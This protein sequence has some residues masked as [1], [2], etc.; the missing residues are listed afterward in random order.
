[1]AQ[2][3]VLANVDGH[4]D[5]HAS[6][7]V[8]QRDTPSVAVKP[9]GEASVK[10]ETCVI[11]MSSVRSRMESEGFSKT[12]TNFI[13]SSWRSSTKGAYDVFIRKWELFADK[14]KVD[15][16]S[17]TVKDAVN[18]L[19]QLVEEGFSYSAIATA[20]SA[21]SSFLKLDNTD[22][23]FGQQE[24]VKRFMKGLFEENPTLPRYV[25]TWD[26]NIVLEFLKS[27]SP[28][29]KLTL[30]ELTLKLCMLLALVTG[31]RCQTL[32]LLNTEHMVV[33]NTKCIFY[34]MSLIKHSRRGSHQE[35]I[36]IDAYPKCTE[37]CVVTVLKEYL[38]RTEMFRK[39]AGSQLF[40]T[41]VSPHSPASKDTVSRWIKTTLSL[42]G[43]EL[44]YS[45]HSTRMAATSAADKCGVPIETI[46]KAAGW[47]N[48][49][50]FGKFY[51]KNVEK[52]SMGQSLLDNFLEHPKK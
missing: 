13:M 41:L 22:K 33:Y 42:A 11:G 23:S 44:N 47:T 17:P 36:E 8:G 38:R 32:H 28:V 27:W 5:R 29:D 9:D 49:S 34:I 37:L 6:S 45:A 3:A 21:L 15:K 31:Q 39:N 43:I 52:T 24:I 50:T 2:P 12:A 18:F 30:K 20:R 40:L 35:P 1:M 7:V 25:C 10:K 14:I 16:V 48:S 19:A 26:V 4:V 46:M 51:R